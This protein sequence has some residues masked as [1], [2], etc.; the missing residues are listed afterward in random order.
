LQERSA[1]LIALQAAAKEFLDSTN[2]DGSILAF[3]DPQTIDIMLCRLG[4][5]SY[6][7]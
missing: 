6:C 3:A 1:P 4:F 7:R 2:T 5:T